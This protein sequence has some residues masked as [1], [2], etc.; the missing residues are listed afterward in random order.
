MTPE[1]AAGRLSRTLMPIQVMAGLANENMTR[2]L[3]WRFLDTGRR[4]DRSLLMLDV[5]SAIAETDAEA[6][7]AALDVALE[8]GDSTMTYRA[9]YLDAPQIVPVMDV[10][11]AD[12]SNPRSLAYQLSRLSWHMDSLAPDQAFGLRT[13]EQRLAIRLLGITRTVDLDRMHLDAPDPQ[14]QAFSLND[15]DAM[16]PPVDLRSLLNLLRGLLEAL[17]ESLARQYFAHAV[18]TRQASGPGSAGVDQGARS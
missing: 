18:E 7:G 12:E 2:G 15:G 1:D 4:I 13:H 16:P 3:G 10:L 11:L 9:R 6:R 14:Q 8:L 17:A 5:F